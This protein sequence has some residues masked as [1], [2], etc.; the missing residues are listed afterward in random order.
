MCGIFALVLKESGNTLDNLINPLKQLYYP[1]CDSLGFYI[2]KSF[3]FRVVTFSPEKINWAFNEQIIPETLKIGMG[4]TRWATQGLS[5]IENVHPIVNGKISVVH[6]GTIDNYKIFKNKLSQEPYNKKFKSDS[7]TEVIAIMIQ[8]Y[9]SQG[10]DLPTAIS[11]TVT[12]LKGIYS[13]VVSDAEENLVAYCNGLP[14]I[15][16]QTVTGTYISSNI[17]SFKHLPDGKIHYLEKNQ[18]AQINH[19]CSVKL[20]DQSDMSGAEIDFKPVNFK[21]STI[22][23][24]MPGLDL[25]AI[26]CYMRT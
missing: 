13:F 15:I 19:D 9:K 4:H 2:Y 25:A 14:L 7:D 26:N 10:W 21:T 3:K 22:Q 6:N 16:F 11:L 24:I 12:D 20:F 5:T 17:A 23:N 8:H 18:I 1:G